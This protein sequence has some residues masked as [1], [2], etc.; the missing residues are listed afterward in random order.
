[1]NRRIPVLMILITLVLSVA[2]LFPGSIQ[3]KGPEKDLTNTEQLRSI[4][5]DYVYTA[6]SLRIDLTPTGPV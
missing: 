2:Y 3:D 6:V 1:M 4:T 5:T